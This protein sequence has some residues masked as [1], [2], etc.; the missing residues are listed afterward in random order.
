MRKHVFCVIGLVS[1]FAVS[2]APGRYASAEETLQES[3][4]IQEQNLR[5]SSAAD[6]R[7]I[8]RE[9]FHLEGPIYAAEDLPSIHLDTPDKTLSVQEQFSDLRDDQ[10]NPH[11]I[12][13]EGYKEE[14]GTAYS[15]YGILVDGK[16]QVECQTGWSYGADLSYLEV[17][18]NSYLYFAD[19]SD[20]DYVNQ[21]NFYTFQDGEFIEA[22]SVTEEL[23]GAEGKLFSNWSRG[24]LAYIGGDT[25]LLLWSDQSPCIGNYTVPV[26]LTAAEDG[27]LSLGTQEFQMLSVNGISRENWTATRSFTTA[28]SPGSDEE[29]FTVSV[30]GRGRYTSYGM[31]E[32]YFFEAFF[33]G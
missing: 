9:L 28:S 8:I 3:S 22:F 19:K 23:R 33:A 17:N 16:K 30:G 25:V 12:V 15:S 31:E 6:K 26:N 13:L 18:G 5:D 20:N 10:G 7:A 2:T 4:K 11:E 21:A 24:N 1:A 14:G 27:T 29:A 32:G